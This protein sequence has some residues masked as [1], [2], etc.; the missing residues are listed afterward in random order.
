[1][2]DQSTEGFGVPCTLGVNRNLEHG[3]LNIFWNRVLA[4]GV[5]AC[6]VRGSENR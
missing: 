1:M 5:R 2:R 3:T 4:C 6:G